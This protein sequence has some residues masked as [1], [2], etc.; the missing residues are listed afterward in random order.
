MK[1]INF[2]LFVAEE[3]HHYDFLVYPKITKVAKGF[4]DQMK[5]TGRGIMAFFGRGSSK[6]PAE[7][8]KEVDFQI[9]STEAMAKQCLQ[10]YLEP[11][12]NLLL[13][14]GEFPAGFNLDHLVNGVAGIYLQHQK[15]CVKHWEQRP[16]YVPVAAIKSVSYCFKQNNV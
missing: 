15:P 5:E 10:F 12:K 14:E 4:F 7:D 11:C 3:Y 6:K 2:F 16:V 13:E 1:K 9:L 8:A